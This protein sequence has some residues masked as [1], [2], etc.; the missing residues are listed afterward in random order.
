M[1]GD[2]ANAVWQRHDWRPDI[3]RHQPVLVCQN[4]GCPIVWWPDRREPKS[5]CHGLTPRQLIEV[6]P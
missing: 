1:T 2:Q 4:P 6:K 3:R 5:A